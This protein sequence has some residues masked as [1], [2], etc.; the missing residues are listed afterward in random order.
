MGWAVHRR[1]PTQIAKTTPCKVK[2]G[3][4]SFRF[5]RKR[6]GSGLR[7]RYVRRERMIGPRERQPR[8]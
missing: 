7:K 4:V 2:M 5:H 8:G 1:A 6:K 3:W